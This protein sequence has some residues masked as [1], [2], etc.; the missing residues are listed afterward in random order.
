MPTRRI[1]RSVLAIRLGAGL[2][3][4]ALVFLGW[5]KSREAP[6]PENLGRVELA[7][8]GLH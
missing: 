4:C 5:W 6:P 8:S 1:D 2:L 7:V 3:V